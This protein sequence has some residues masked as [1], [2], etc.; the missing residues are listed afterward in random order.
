MQ[1]ISTFTPAFHSFPWHNGPLLNPDKSVAA[2]FGTRQRLTRSGWPTPIAV[3]GSDIKMSDHLKVL[4]VTLDSSMTLDTQ[5]TATVRSCYF[6]LHSLRQL[7]SSLPRDRVGGSSNYK[8]KCHIFIQRN[9]LINLIPNLT[10]FEKN[11]IWPLF[12]PWEPQRVGSPSNFKIKSK[13]NLYS[14]VY[15]TDSEALGRWIKWGRRNDTDKFFKCFLKVSVNYIDRQPVPQRRCSN[16]ERSLGKFSAHSRH[17]QARRA[18]RL[19][20][21]VTGCDRLAVNLGTAVMTSD[22]PWTSEW[23]LCVWCVRQPF[24]YLRDRWEVRNWPIVGEFVAVEAG[25]FQERQTLCRLESPQESAVA[26]WQVSHVSNEWLAR[27]HQHT[28][29]AS[30]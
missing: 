14:A 4:G 26:E 2:L 18:G 13:K 3:T 10:G 24:Q 7:R 8:T 20:R 27:T 17:D 30:A 12:D 22:E 5:V 23:R 28:R 1:T 29:A 21:P 11:G 25:I 15:S 6:H 9:F 19:E 16:A